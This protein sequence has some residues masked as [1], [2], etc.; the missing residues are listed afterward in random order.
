MK[1]TGWRAFLRKRILLYITD[2]LISVKIQKVAISMV[3]FT[4]FLWTE[5][6]VVGSLQSRRIL[7]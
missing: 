6:L 4:G 1:Q 2:R 3:G 5:D 7:G